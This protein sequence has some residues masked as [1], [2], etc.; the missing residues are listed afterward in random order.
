V[1]E[2]GDSAAGEAAGPVDS[3]VFEGRISSET[4]DSSRPRI[5]PDHISMRLNH[6]TPIS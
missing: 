4:I 3:R 6:S 1:R 5:E 2:A